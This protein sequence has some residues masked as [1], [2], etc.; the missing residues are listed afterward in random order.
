[1]YILCFT[2]RRKMQHNYYL[3]CTKPMI[4]NRL[5]KILDTNPLLIKSLGDYLHPYPLIVYIIYKYWGRIDIIKNKK[6]LV[7]DYNWYES[8]PKHPSQDLLEFMRS[9]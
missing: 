6:K 9:C 3:Q 8:D 5:L 2:Q 1:M 4:E 7:H